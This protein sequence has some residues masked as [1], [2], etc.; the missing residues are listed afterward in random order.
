MSR[1]GGRR[2]IDRVL[3]GAFLDGLSGWTMAVLRAKRAE[4]EQE[5]VDLSYSRR[6]LHGR[7]DLLNA[8]HDTRQ[9]GGRHLANGSGDVVA[10]LAGV[11]ADA[12][13]APFGMGRHAV[14]SPTRAGEHRR[15]AEAAVADVELS[16]P[17]ALDDEALAAAIAQLSGLERQ[18]G[19]AR[20]EV[21]AVLDA[22]SAEV[23]RRYRD[24]EANVDDVLSEAMHAS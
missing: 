1:S 4:A 21:Q 19:D 2:R 23:A 15:A 17:G 11:L 12:P 5:E 22:L 24:G 8:E 13:A 9:A 6:L 7:I 10:R 16:D 3:G 18:V 20:R 14:M